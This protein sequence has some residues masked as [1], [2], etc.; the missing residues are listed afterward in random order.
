MEKTADHKAIG[1]HTS[2]KCIFLTKK[3]DSRWSKIALIVL[4]PLSSS[5]DSA[6]AQLKTVCDNKPNYIRLTTRLGAPTGFGGNYETEICGIPLHRKYSSATFAIEV[7]G[8]AG[9]GMGIYSVN[10]ANKPKGYWA[11]KLT[12]NGYKEVI[13]SMLPDAL[14]KAAEI[15]C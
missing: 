12:I 14:N 7:N 13:E 11:S 3:P 10:C 8:K 4:T 9:S 15:F 2:E 6:N 5:K 1:N